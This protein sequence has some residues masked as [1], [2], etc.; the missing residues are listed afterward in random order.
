[1]DKLDAAATLGRGLRHHRIPG[2]GPAGPRLACAGR[3]RLPDDVSG[4][5]GQGTGR[6]RRCAPPDPAALP[7]RLSRA[8]SPAPATPLATTP[9]SGAKCWTPRRWNGSR[10]TAA[11][12]GPTATSSAAELLSRGNS[13]DPLDSFRASRG[14]GAESRTAAQA[15]RA[16]LTPQTHKT[17]PASHLRKVTGRRR[18]NQKREA[19]RRRDP[20]ARVKRPRLR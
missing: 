13:R 10:T 16:R 4:V 9:T 18:S 19:T 3:H 5:R 8:S 2:C 12:P 11:S 1:M 15:P 14:R 7:H 6:G 20:A 17:T